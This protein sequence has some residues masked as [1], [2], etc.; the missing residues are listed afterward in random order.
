MNLMKLETG[1]NGLFLLEPKI[2]RDTRG[3]FFESYN[4]RAMSELGLDYNFVQDNESQ[5]VYGTVRGLHFQK[6]EF[7][8]AK[9]VRVISGEVL[10][11][12]VDLR[13][14]EPTYGR[15]Y[16]VRLD[17]TNRLMMIIPRGFAHGFAVLSESAVFS[18]K[19]DN[20]YSPTNEGGL[21]YS[22]PH[23]NIDWC[24][25][26]EKLILSDKDRKHPTFGALTT[27]SANTP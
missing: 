12:V 3:Y 26:T 19:C 23:L 10:D 22:D 4:G 1:F 27:Q 24:I 14:N 21:L 8:Q 20:F 16:A 2:F 13:K 6:G 25:P 15:H 11:V 17:S 18:Y 7:A 5:S 9:L